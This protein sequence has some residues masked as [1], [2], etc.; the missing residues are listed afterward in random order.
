MILTSSL[1]IVI[2]REARIVHACVGI[3]GDRVSNKVTES[4]TNDEYGAV[5]S[6]KEVNVLAVGV[7]RGIR[8]NHNGEDDGRLYKT[9]ILGQERRARMT[10]EHTFVCQ[11]VMVVAVATTNIWPVRDALRDMTGSLILAAGFPI[12]SGP[13]GGPGNAPSSPL[14][15]TDRTAG[16]TG[17]TGV[18]SESWSLSS[19]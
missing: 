6:E 1:N 5:R 19:P 16:V 8:A 13:A 18:F 12:L 14:S 11:T 4:S 9:Q 17:V 3:G 15:S 2:V 7:E 10:W